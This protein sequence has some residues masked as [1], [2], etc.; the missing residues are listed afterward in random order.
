MS[1]C[2]NDRVQT[3]SCLV[4]K[5]PGRTRPSL[6]GHSAGTLSGSDV[7][8]EE[9]D[10]TGQRLSGTSQGPEGALGPGSPD[11][12]LHRLTSVTATS[13]ESQTE[14]PWAGAGAGSQAGT[15]AGVRGQSGSASL[16][17]LEDAPGGA[18][19]PKR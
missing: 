4:P 9:L 5:W 14:A 18:R 11:G 6:C 16:R 2:T 8:P 15:G 1:H 10:V 19:G 7:P 13:R 12:N 17:T 3:L